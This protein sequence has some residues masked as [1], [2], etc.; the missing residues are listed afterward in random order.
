MVKILKKLNK[1]AKL[2][3]VEKVTIFNESFSVE[4]QVTVIPCHPEDATINNLPYQFIVEKDD[5]VKVNNEHVYYTKSEIED[6]LHSPELK[7][8]ILKQIV[9]KIFK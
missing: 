6:I 3:I 4:A 2:N 1:T 7:N 9:K 5:F 8:L